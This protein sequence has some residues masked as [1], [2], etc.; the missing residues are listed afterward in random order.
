MA[1]R[2]HSPFKIV[3]AQVNPDRTLREDRGWHKM[4]VQ[5][6]ITDKTVGST[7]TV[8]GRTTMPPGVKAQHALHRHPNAEEWEIVLQGVGLKHVGDQSFLLKPGELAFVP[9][10]VYHG[11]ENPS[12]SETLVTLWGYCGASSL[13]EAGYIIPEDDPDYGKR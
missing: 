10:D 8:V 12:D 5:W 4:D 13:E 2:E 3:P 6:L 11:L 7:L 1:P 9:R